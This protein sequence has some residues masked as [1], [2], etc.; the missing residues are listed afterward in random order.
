[1]LHSPHHC[2]AARSPSNNTILNIKWTGNLPTLSNS[3]L[4]QIEFH[5]TVVF[6]YENRI[7]RHVLSGLEKAVE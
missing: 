1:M 3:N 2:V 5:T 4:F 7:V 6:K